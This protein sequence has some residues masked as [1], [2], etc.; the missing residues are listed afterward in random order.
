[1][2]DS[3]K[4]NI[5]S[6]HYLYKFNS[7]TASCCSVY[8]TGIYRSCF[9]DQDNSL[10]TE[11][12]WAK[13]YSF[14]RRIKLYRHFFESSSLTISRCG[15]SSLQP[16]RYVISCVLV[17]LMTTDDRYQINSDLQT[18][19]PTATLKSSQWR[20]CDDFKMVLYGLRRELPF[21]L[22]NNSTSG[23]LRTRL[24]YTVTEN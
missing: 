7:K 12:T 22:A 13:N 14:C 11:I 10:N 4:W 23:N 19:A 5:K 9:G 3:I 2:S 17:V 18:K 20:H 1:M 24:E 6:H 16:V 15:L 21:P 8:T